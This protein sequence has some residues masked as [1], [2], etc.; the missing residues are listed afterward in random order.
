MYNQVSSWPAS[1]D[2]EAGEKVGRLRLKDMRRENPFVRMFKALMN[3]YSIL[4]VLLALFLILSVFVESFFR[5]SNITNVLRQVSMVSIVAVARPGHP[6]PSASPRWR[7]RVVDV[8]AI[9]VSSTDLRSRCASG[10]PIDYLVPDAVRSVIEQR[11]LYG[12]RR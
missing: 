4:F 1:G 6:A 2:P 3:D 5:I 11:G 9:E 10:A 12:V 8:P 7:L